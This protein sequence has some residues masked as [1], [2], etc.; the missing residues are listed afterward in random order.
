MVASGTA[1]TPRKPHR[2]LAFL[3]K[4]PLRLISLPLVSKAF[5]YWLTPSTPGMEASHAVSG[6]NKVNNLSELP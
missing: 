3:K 5:F 2:S 4:I 1:W 6:D